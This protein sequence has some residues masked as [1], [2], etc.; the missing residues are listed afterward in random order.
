MA[1]VVAIRLMS[2]I[3]NRVSRWSR[4]HERSRAR[5]M[6]INSVEAL[7]N[8]PI[9]NDNDEVWK[10][11]DNVNELEPPDEPRHHAK[12]FY[13]GNGR[14][15]NTASTLSKVPIGTQPAP[16]NVLFEHAVLGLTKRRPGGDHGVTVDA[17][18]LALVLTDMVEVQH[19][20]FADLR[21]DSQRDVVL[22]DR[23]NSYGCFIDP[24]GRGL[25][26]CGW[27]EP[28]SSP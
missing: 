22:R 27:T 9:V 12:M 13:R 18:C 11:H 14:V 2:V 21:Q 6:S 1:D 24:E 26:L 3:R 25:V 28:E 7:D 19:A 8:E 15:I 16:C 17:I 10:Y 4:E 20:K 23:Q 5:S